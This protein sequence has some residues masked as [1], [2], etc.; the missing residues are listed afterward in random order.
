VISTAFAMSPAPRIKSRRANHVPDV[1]GI[2][3]KS[4]ARPLV[5]VTSETGPGAIL[6]GAVGLGVGFLSGVA[7]YYAETKSG[8]TVGP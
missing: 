3:S 1:P 4:A 7:V 6:G 8:C 2:P 5:S